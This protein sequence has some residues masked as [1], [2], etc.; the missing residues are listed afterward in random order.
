[1]FNRIYSITSKG[2]TE[3]YIEFQ[4]TTVKFKDQL[5]QNPII[6]ESNNNN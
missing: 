5:A 4:G 6:F 3:Y 2:T 1:M